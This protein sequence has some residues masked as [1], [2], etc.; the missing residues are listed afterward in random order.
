MIFGVN[1]KKS[2]DHLPEQVSGLF[3]SFSN[4]LK[5]THTKEP[6]VLTQFCEH[7]W[8]LLQ[9]FSNQSLVMSSEV[10]LSPWIPSLNKHSSS[11]KHSLPIWEKPILHWHWYVPWILVQDLYDKVSNNSQQKSHRWVIQ[12]VILLWATPYPYSL[13]KWVPS[14]HSSMSIHESLSTPSTYPGSHR[15]ENEP[16]IRVLQAVWPSLSCQSGPSNPDLCI[17]TCTTRPASW[18]TT[19][20]SLCT[21]IN[22]CKSF[23]KISRGLRSPRNVFFFKICLDILDRSFYIQLYTDIQRI[24]EYSS[25]RIFPHHNC[26]DYSHIHR[27]LYNPVLG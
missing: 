18:C 10:R 1:Q 13:H 2:F 26:A 24:Q 8:V 21:F 20:W 17:K 9:G 12:R 6:M 14:L 19:A 27:S 3:K 7:P 22:I 25:K 15:H 5:Q 23:D 11:S 16:L 4:P